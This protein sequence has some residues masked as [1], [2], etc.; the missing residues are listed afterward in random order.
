MAGGKS[1]YFVFLIMTARPPSD[2]ANLYLA[3]SQSQEEK[4]KLK[5]RRNS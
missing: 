5:A 3:N 2:A 4:L 1:K